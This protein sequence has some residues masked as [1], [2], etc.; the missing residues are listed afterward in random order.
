MAFGNKGGMPPIARPAAPMMG[1]GATA[2]LSRPIP[3]PLPAVRKAP[4]RGGKRK[5]GGFPMGRSGGSRF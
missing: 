4:K 3:S 2:P 5:A 1:G